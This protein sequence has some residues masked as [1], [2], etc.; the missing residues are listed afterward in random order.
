MAYPVESTAVVTAAIHRVIRVSRRMK[1]AK[2]WITKGE[3]FNCRT[4]AGSSEY[5]QHAW[6]NGID[7][8]THAHDQ[9][10]DLADALVVQ[11]KRRTWANHGRRL[12]IS[13]VIDHDG[14]RVWEPGTGWRPYNGTTGAHIHVSGAPYRTGKPPCAA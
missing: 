6:G 12:P 4:V 8:F 5:S 7:L 10:A 1:R 11:A 2:H 9:L 13:Q 3:V 14:R